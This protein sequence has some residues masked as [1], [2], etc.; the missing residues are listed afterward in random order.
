MVRDS[1]SSA[2]LVPPNTEHFVAEITEEDVARAALDAA[3]AGNG[4]KETLP[5]SDAEAEP[6]DAQLDQAEKSDAS[7]TRAREASSPLFEA[8]LKRLK[9]IMRNMRP[10]VVQVSAAGTS[11]P[12]D[13][14]RQALVFTNHHKTANLVTE[15]LRRARIP[16]PRRAPAPAAQSS[17]LVPRR[18]R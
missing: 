6:M 13:L 9:Q 15:R 4:G 18:L 14:N 8:K 7:R 5:Q 12:A 16:V 3:S 17:F 1:V 11:A 2:C 10:G